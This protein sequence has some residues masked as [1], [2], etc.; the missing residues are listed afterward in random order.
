[1]HDEHNN[2]MHNAKI[3]QKKNHFWLVVGGNHKISKIT[4]FLILYDNLID[5]FHDCW[6]ITVA[7]ISWLSEIVW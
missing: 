4:V 7:H 1:M 6:F 3:E 2:I 5:W